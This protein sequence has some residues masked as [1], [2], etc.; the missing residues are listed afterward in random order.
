[1][2]AAGRCPVVPPEVQRYIDEVK[3]CL[4]HVVESQRA[5]RRRPQPPL[6]PLPALPLMQPTLC[7]I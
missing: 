6:P 5:H 4:L 3:A 2:D 1:M 7:R